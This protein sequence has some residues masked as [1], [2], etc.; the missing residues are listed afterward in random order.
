MGNRIYQAGRSTRGWARDK[1]LAGLP[2]AGDILIMVSHRFEA[3]NL[4]KVVESGEPRTPNGFSYVYT[5][6]EGNPLPPPDNVWGMFIHGF[7][8]AKPGGTTDI[9]HAVREGSQGP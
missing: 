2:K 3:E 6:P 8:C 1:R 5:D 9:Y 4:I 7:E